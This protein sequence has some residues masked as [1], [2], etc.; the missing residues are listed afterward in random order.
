MDYKYNILENAKEIKLN[1]FA[2]VLQT[3]HAKDLSEKYKF[4]PTFRVLNG[5]GGQNRLKWNVDTHLGRF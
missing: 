2:S 1:N 5:C 3:T 4:I